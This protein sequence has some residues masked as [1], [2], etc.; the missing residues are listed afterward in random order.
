M[1]I[2]ELTHQE[3]SFWA[4]FAGSILEKLFGNIRDKVKLSKIYQDAKQRFHDK[5]ELEALDYFYQW[6]LNHINENIDVKKIIKEVMKKQELENLI[7]NKVREII[8]EE[9]YTIK[10]L[11]EKNKYYKTDSGLGGI[12]KLKYIGFK[13]GKHSYEIQ[14]KDFSHWDFAIPETEVLKQIRPYQ[15]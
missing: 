7:E 9:Q 14:N 2:N 5:R 11:T 12:F 13:N 10:D 8:K 4:L 6:R 15:N 3:I 1:N